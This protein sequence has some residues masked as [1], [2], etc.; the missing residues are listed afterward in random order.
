MSLIETI[1]GFISQ[2]FEPVTKLVDELHTSE[3]ERNEF[4]LKLEEIRAEIKKAENLVTEKLIEFHMKL[5]DSQQAIIVAEAQGDSWL[6][7]NWRPLMML[8]FAG[9]IGFTWAGLSSDTV[10][11]EMQLKLLDIVHGGLYGYMGLRTVEKVSNVIRKKKQNQTTN[12]LN[13]IK[14]LIAK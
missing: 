8:L 10:D 9:V 13:G 5:I 2:I 6:Q 14:K 7:R 11:S 4:K 1:T 3:E 12:M